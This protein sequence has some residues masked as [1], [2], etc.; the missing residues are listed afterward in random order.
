MTL[1]KIYLP[2]I[3][4]SIFLALTVIGLIRMVYQDADAPGI[5]I[6]A[7]LFFY[8]SSLIIY[9][10]LLGYSFSSIGKNSPIGLFVISLLPAVAYLWYLL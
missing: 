1:K 5:V 3:F 8:G 7:N 4:I 2:R 10:I 9:L 6:L